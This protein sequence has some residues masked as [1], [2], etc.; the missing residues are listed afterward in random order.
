VDTLQPSSP[1]SLVGLVHHRV[2]IAWR[3][4]ADVMTSFRAKGC[5]SLAAS[6][7][8]FSLLSL[9]PMVFLLL[10]GISFLVDQSRIGHEFLL[11][12]LKGFLPTLSEGLAY[13]IRR[14]SDLDNVRWIVFASFA[15]LGA[16]VF[17]ELDYALHVV[18]GTS[19]QRHTLL[20]TAI[21]VVL[22]AAFGGLVILSYVAT[23]IVEFF[24]AHTPHVW[25]FDL[26][27]VAAHD[28]LLTYTLPF[29]FA[30][31]TVIC[32]YRSVPAQRPTWREAAWG[33]G[34]FALLWV[35]AKSLSAAY[36]QQATVYSRLYGS[37]LEVVL[38]L[39]WI[40]YSALLVLLGAVVTHRLQ[41]RRQGP[42]SP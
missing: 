23:Q 1:F 38:L 18:F 39:L 10:Y 36:M 11:S 2:R 28:I 26:M 30:F 31:A 19:R 21:A 33:A 16:S 22:L 13:Q 12:F 7:A 41:L 24:T 8:F 42:L 29:G 5:A 40:Y 34:C 9:F 6:L 3:F 27:A 32:L 37:V 20:S 17:Y 14:I 35:A 4:L 15:W 25:G